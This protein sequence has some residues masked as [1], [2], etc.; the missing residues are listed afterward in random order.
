[1]N[2]LERDT[3]FKILQYTPEDLYTN[4]TSILEKVF[5]KDNMRIGYEFLYAKGS[6]P[7]LLVAHM[8]TVF[9]QPPK[10]MF[11]DQDKNVLWCPYGAGFDDRVGVF[12][13]Y[14]LLATGLRPSILLT[15]GEEHGGYGAIE[16]IEKIESINDKYVIELDRHGINDAVFYDEQN[17]EFKEYITSFGFKEADG[18]FSWNKPCVNLSVGYFDEH[19]QSERLY[20]PALERTIDKVREMIKASYTA[21]Y[22]KSEL[23]PYLYCDI[24]NQPAY[25]NDNGM[26]VEIDKR[27]VYFCGDC[28]NKY[29]EKLLKYKK[30][31]YPL[32]PIE[33]DEFEYEDC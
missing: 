10:E 5:G 28:Y 6:S 7:V 32:F 22:F 12:G 1:M 11:W 20:I 33:D 27:T 26:F 2:Q 15:L 31:P 19:T 18:I 3:L 8:D 9:K 17:P 4:M 13:I 30:S 21:P 23:E 16:T 14:Y 24:C 25:R 29:H